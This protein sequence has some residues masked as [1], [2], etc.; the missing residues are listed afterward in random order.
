MPLEYPNLFTKTA[1]LTVVKMVSQVE[2][3]LMPILEESDPGDM[4]SQ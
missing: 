2:K 1:L 3:F 4:L